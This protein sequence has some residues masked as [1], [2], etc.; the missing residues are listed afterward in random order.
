MR[1]G[2]D[3]IGQAAAALASVSMAFRP[4]D[5]NYSAALLSNATDLFRCVALFALQ[6]TPIPSLLQSLPRRRL[7]RP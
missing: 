6:E 1:A 2:S 3:A 5:A 7:S 4:I